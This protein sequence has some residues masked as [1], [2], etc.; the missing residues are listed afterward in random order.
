[1]TLWTLAVMIG[2]IWCLLRGT[3]NG[4]TL[5]QGTLIA[6]A[7]LIW[8]R[9]ASGL[10]AALHW[11]RISIRLPIRILIDLIRSSLRVALDVVTPRDRFAPR[12]IGVPID[13]PSDAAVTALANA[14][15]LTPGTLTVD[16]SA[17]RRVIYVHAMYASDA[18]AVRRMIKERLEGDIRVLFSPPTEPPP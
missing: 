4:P 8:L 1:M 3:I 15:S 11:A 9:R 7:I 13:L 6:V 14:I 2:L 10:A 12:I 5:L 17:D 16:V 18:D